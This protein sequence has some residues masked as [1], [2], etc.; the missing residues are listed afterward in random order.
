MKRLVEL[1]HESRSDSRFL[2]F[3]RMLD[4]TKTNGFPR[5]LLEKQDSRAK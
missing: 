2:K 1:R 3:P 4:T 5:L